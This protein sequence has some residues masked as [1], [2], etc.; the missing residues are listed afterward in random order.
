MLNQEFKRLLLDREKRTV[1]SSLAP[2]TLPEEEFPGEKTWRDQHSQSHLRQEIMIQLSGSHS[3]QFQ[4]KNYRA[5]PGTV[6]I[7]NSRERHDDG[8]FP[9]PGKSA[10]LWLIL[11]PDFINCQCDEFADGKLQISFRHFCRNRERIAE[12]NRVWTAGARGK[13]APQTALLALLALLDLVIFDILEAEQNLM[14]HNLDPRIEAVEKVKS[15]LESTVG[16][17]CSLTFLAGLAGY[18]PMHFQRLFKKYTGMTVGDYINL[19]RIKRYDELK[20]ICPQKEIAAELGFSSPS[21]FCN[22]LRRQ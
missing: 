1:I 6:L 4:G 11:R 7:L 16:R 8:Y 21:A 15:Y 19:L 5:Q 12:I 18:S 2:I 10:H 17:N 22:W 20:N 3:V 9:G 13:I 14:P